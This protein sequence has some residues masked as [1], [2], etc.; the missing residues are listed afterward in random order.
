MPASMMEPVVEDSEVGIKDVNLTTNSTY[1]I[2]NDEEASTSETNTTLIDK[3]D[4][5]P[6]T[7][8]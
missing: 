8:V 4:S 5:L 3:D 1:I 2:L 6:L 7:K